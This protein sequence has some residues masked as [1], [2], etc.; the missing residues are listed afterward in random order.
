ML[1]ALRRPT[2]RKNLVTN[3]TPLGRTQLTVPKDLTLRLFLWYPS[4]TD[5][6]RRRLA[7]LAAEWRAL[8][9][10]LEAANKLLNWRAEDIEPRFASPRSSL[11]P[12]FITAEDPLAD[13]GRP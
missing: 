7:R 11:N 4:A 6:Q 5:E 1:S 9:G 10:E 12:A 2:K 3:E 13:E 8:K